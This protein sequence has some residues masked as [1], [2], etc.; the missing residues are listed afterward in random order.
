VRTHG[1]K[2][3][4]HFFVVVVGYWERSCLCLI[5]VMR[6]RALITPGGSRSRMT[7]A[8]MSVM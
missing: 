3:G 4:L 6:L 2:R 1:A 5:M 7:I 8:Y